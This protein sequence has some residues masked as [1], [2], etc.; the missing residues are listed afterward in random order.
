ME[1]IM[2]IQSAGT[3]ELAIFSRVLEPEKA[4]LSSAA[5]RAILDLT[6]S[7]ADMNRMQQ[8]SAKAREGSLS[9]DERVEIDNYELVGHIISLMKSKARRSLRVRSN[10][11][12]KT[13]VL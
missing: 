9:P 11:R 7:E 12:R 5:A 3:S 2:S 13:K 8:L 6:F 1:Q 10:P 4:T